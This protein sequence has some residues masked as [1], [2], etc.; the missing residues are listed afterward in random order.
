MVSRESIEVSLYFELGNQIFLR[1]PYCGEMEFHSVI[2]FDSKLFAVL[3][4][5]KFFSNIQIVEGDVRQRR[6]HRRD[7]DLPGRQPLPRPQDG[8]RSRLD[9]LQEVLQGNQVQNVSKFSIFGP[10]Y[11]SEGQ[12][13][14]YRATHLLAD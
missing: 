3:L 14:L 5:I 8:P 10:S 2:V 7:S 9:L 12:K 1:E 13:L 11:F 4:L 6:S